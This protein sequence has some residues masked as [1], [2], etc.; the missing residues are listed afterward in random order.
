[1]VSRLESEVE[2]MKLCFRATVLTFIIIASCFLFGC[3]QS[4]NSA[5]S[6]SIASS[7]QSLSSEAAEAVEKATSEDQQTAAEGWLYLVE[8]QD[9]S[10]V[11]AAIEELGGYPDPFSIKFFFDFGYDASSLANAIMNGGSSGKYFDECVAKVTHNSSGKTEDFAFRAD[12]LGVGTLYYMTY[13]CGSFPLWDI[14]TFGSDP[15]LLVLKEKPADHMA[16]T[17]LVIEGSDSPT[18]DVLDTKMG[19]DYLSSLGLTVLDSK[20]YS[21]YPTADASSMSP[22]N[23]GV[24][25]FKTEYRG[26]TIC[27]VAWNEATSRRSDLTWYMAYYPE[28]LASVSMSD[29]DAFMQKQAETMIETRRWYCYYDS[30]FLKSLGVELESPAQ[31]YASKPESN[32]T[33]ESSSNSASSK[34]D[35]LIVDTDTKKIYKVWAYD[36]TIQFSGSYEGTGN[37][38]VKVLD[39]NQDLYNLVANEIGTYVVEKKVPVTKGK[40]YYIQIEVN[41][42]SWS[43]KWSGTYGQ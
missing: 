33:P 39:D 9:D 35:E 41:D 34:K 21:D 23:I 3:Q 37:F 24:Y 22:L 1:M 16:G 6:A 20:V 8:N 28:T 43:M 19:A 11:A 7:S 30:E 31:D 14:G 40:M 5:S 26:E 17:T 12:T 32:S 18:E 25:I 29:L 4:S 15:S 10:A 27:G 2:T 38:I 36:D 13:Q 42:G